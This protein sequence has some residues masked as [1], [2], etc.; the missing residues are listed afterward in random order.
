[1]KTCR[2]TIQH[3]MT[4]NNILLVNKRHVTVFM[5]NTVYDDLN[6]EKDVKFGDDD[7]KYNLDTHSHPKFFSIIFQ[8]VQYP[9]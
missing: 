8:V 3:A 5:H 6:I 4:A 2:V 9:C 1:M 7:N